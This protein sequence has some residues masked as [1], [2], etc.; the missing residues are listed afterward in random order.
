MI[1]LRVSATNSNH[2]RD[3]KE[4]YKEAIRL[5]VDELLFKLFE[6]LFDLS[7]FCNV[8]REE[9]EG[10]NVPLEIEPSALVPWLKSHYPECYVI[11]PNLQC[12]RVSA[13]SLEE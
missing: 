13:F 4:M 12:G 10:P 2:T 6:I 7:D 1:V 9:Q 8:Q 5:L 3:W 11:T